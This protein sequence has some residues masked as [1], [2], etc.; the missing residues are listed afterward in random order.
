MAE[1]THLEA[2]LNSIHSKFISNSETL[3]VAESCTGGG[4]GYALTQLSGSSAYFQ[5]GIV[6]YANA[7]KTGLLGVSKQQIAA[8]G[9]VSKEVAL[10]MANGCIEAMGTTWAIAITGIAG[11][12][13]GSPAKPVGTVWIAHT[14]HKRGVLECKQHRFA[15]DPSATS[16]A[17]EAIRSQAIAAALQRLDQLL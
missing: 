2:V 8:Q 10:A 14:S 15:P 12:T 9:A 3:G 16:S 7:I 13:G 17:R 6:S 4:L 11:P 5:G 1:N